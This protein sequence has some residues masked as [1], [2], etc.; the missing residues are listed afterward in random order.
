MVV[1]VGVALNGL[2][3]LRK[4]ASLGVWGGWRLGGGHVG[5]G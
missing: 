2:D 5:E 3:V 4:F 1:S